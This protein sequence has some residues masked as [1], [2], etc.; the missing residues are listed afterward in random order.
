MANPKNPKIQYLVPE[1]SEHLGHMHMPSPTYKH[2]HILS[3]TDI[4]NKY[5][6]R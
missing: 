6:L 3:D 4:E 2:K 5:N 1:H